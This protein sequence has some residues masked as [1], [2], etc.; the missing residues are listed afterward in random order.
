MPW[1]AANAAYL[2]LKAA[3]TISRCDKLL[4]CWHI[5][6][7]VTP[8]RHF[9]PKEWMLHKSNDLRLLLLD[10]TTGFNQREL[11]KNNQNKIVDGGEGGWGF[12]PS[13]SYYP[14]RIP[15]SFT[16]AM[17]LPS[18]MKRW[19]QVSHLQPSCTYAQ[20]EMS[21]NPRRFRWPSR[22]RLQSSE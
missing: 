8:N 15:S 3:W 21:R 17:K 18:V 7:C 5:S 2:W 19:L 22:L 12:M 9:T 6:I 13:Q 16:I 4:T 14:T 10:F 1:N 20:S 11:I